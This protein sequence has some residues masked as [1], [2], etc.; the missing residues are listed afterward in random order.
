[1]YTAVEKDA[2]VQNLLR[3]SGEDAGGGSIFVIGRRTFPQHSMLGQ[4]VPPPTTIVVLTLFFVSFHFQ[5]QMAVHL[6]NSLVCRYLDITP[7]PWLRTC[8]EHRIPSACLLCPLHFL[9][10]SRG[11]DDIG[12]FGGRKFLFL[13]ECRILRPAWDIFYYHL[14]ER[15]RLRPLAGTG[16]LEQSAYRLLF[17]PI[18][19][20]GLLY[21]EYPLDGLC[22]VSVPP[23]RG[24]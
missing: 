15:R 12:H 3:E 11:P 16:V 7:T 24:S 8:C 20:H 6:C 10:K 9:W 5:T 14:R 18:L 1:M 17:G 21:S 22:G 2:G 19:S 4:P 23:H 13:D